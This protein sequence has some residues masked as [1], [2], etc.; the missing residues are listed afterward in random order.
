M[1]TNQ[2]LT[3][4]GWQILVADY[5]NPTDLQFKLA[6]VDV[7]ISTISGRAQLALINAAS[8]SQVR[9]FIPSEFAG[10]PGLRPANDP[11]DQGRHAALQ[12]LAELESMGMN[13][14]VFSCG[15]FYERFAPG[16]LQ[17]SQLG[18][19]SHIAGEGEYL[20]D[21]RRCRAEVPYYSIAG[22][23]VYVCM[24]SA[25]DAAR[26][27]VASLDLASWPKIFQLR[28]DRLTV[29]HVVGIAEQVR[30]SFSVHIRITR[31]ISFTQG[32]YLSVR[33]TLWTRYMTLLSTPGRFEKQHERHNSNIWSQQPKVGMIFK[34]STGHQTSLPSS[35]RALRSGSSAFGAV[36]QLDETQ[37]A[38]MA[39]RGRT[40]HGHVAEVGTRRSQD[41]Q[42]RGYWC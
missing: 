14:T 4:Q 9:R 36:G 31:L 30:G 5:E 16:G 3:Q 7:V 40:L 33:Y 1:Q 20:L 11:F 10:N 24:T 32:S 26:A 12:R 15:L 39:V 29:E 42:R 28:G 19:S 38:Q 6:G 25:Q 27:V 18:L 17:Q 23:P 37:K 41:W 34:M 8:V 35:W 21:F 22:P 13:S 2:G